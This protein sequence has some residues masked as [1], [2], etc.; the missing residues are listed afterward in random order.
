MLYVSGV[1]KDVVVGVDGLRCAC[2]S[3]SLLSFVALLFSRCCCRG[4][5]RFFGGSSGG[6]GVDGELGSPL[7]VPS[8]EERKRGRHGG[9]NRSG[10]AA[11]LALAI[12]LLLLL[13]ATSARGAAGD[14]QHDLGEALEQAA[15]AT[16]SSS[17]SSASATASSPLQLRGGDEGS[18]LRAVRG[19][20][21]ERRRGSDLER[22][23]QA[24]RESVPSGAARGRRSSSIVVLLLLS[25]VVVFVFSVS[26]EIKDVNG[27]FGQ[28]GLGGPFR[29]VLLLLLLRIFSREQSREGDA[30]ELALG[31]REEDGRG[32]RRSFSFSFSLGVDAHLNGSLSLSPP[33]PLLLFFLLLFRPLLLLLPPHLLQEGKV[34]APDQVR[35]LDVAS[36]KL[37]LLG[38]ERDGGGG[39]RRP[40]G[41][42][43]RTDGGGGSSSG[44]RQEHGAR[45]S[46][47]RSGCR[48]R[49]CRRGPEHA[50][51]DAVVVRVDP[52]AALGSAVA[53]E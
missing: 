9:G 30:P 29:V 7:L 47:R 1:A 49:R 6:S 11:V 53:V 46:W 35:V 21:H 25:V 50:E 51:L 32:R 4:S 28:E 12:L 33:A 3:S 14:V 20:S 37:C 18:R 42:R 43:T 36:E 5:G 15:G 8:S 31:R 39:G 48:R 16:A 40:G 24:A 44:R 19:G 10:R 22:E 34:Q 2:R 38:G 41:T 17:A 26:S 52:L 23:A 45:G 13:L 27:P